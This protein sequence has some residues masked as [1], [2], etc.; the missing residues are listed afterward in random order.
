MPW[1]MTPRNIATL[2]KSMSGRP[3]GWGIYN[4]YN[5]CSAEMRSLLM[6]FGIFLPRNSA[7]Q[8]QATTRMIDLSKEDIGPRINYLKEHGKPFTTLIY[9]TGHIMLYIGNTTINGQ[10]V[11]MTYQN[12]WGLHTP[13]S[14]SRSIIGGSVFFPI[15]PSYPEEPEL[16]SLA[17]K[18]LFKL[19]F[20][21]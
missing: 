16:I 6:P 14:R 4:F 1:E 8:V 21:E 19:G 18:P 2:M 15:L 9:I 5:D 3:H 11:P 20:I 12:I 7:A 10:E 17:G 13:D